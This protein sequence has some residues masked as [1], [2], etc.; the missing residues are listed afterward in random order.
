MKYSVSDV[1]ELGHC[2]NGGSTTITI[3]CNKYVPELKEDFL[4]IIDCFDHCSIL[5]DPE[6]KRWCK[7]YFLVDGTEYDFFMDIA[8]CLKY[9]FLQGGFDISDYTI[10]IELNKEKFEIPLSEVDLNGY[11]IEMGAQEC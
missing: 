3:S 7:R 10:T 1:V 6:V 2:D 5:K 8:L 11:D 9:L 4:K